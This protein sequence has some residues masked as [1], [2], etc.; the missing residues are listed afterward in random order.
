[1][2]CGACVLAI[3]TQDIR[4][5]VLDRAARGLTAAPKL[6]PPRRQQHI[7]GDARLRVPP[8]HV[9]PKVC[10]ELS[11]PCLGGVWQPH[12]VS[13]G[14]GGVALEARLAD[15]RDEERPR[16]IWNT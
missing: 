16:D 11:H 10:D 6:P 7:L 4:D 1:M 13:E 9:A 12:R 8:E 14:G 5:G 3:L 15:L 2:P